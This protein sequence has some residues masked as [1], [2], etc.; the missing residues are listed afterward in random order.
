M[1]SE[2]QR[3]HQLSDAIDTGNDFYAL[4]L[5]RIDD[6]ELDDLMEKNLAERRD[7]LQR[8]RSLDG[9]YTGE[10]SLSTRLEVEQAQ[11]SV[12]LESNDR[13]VY[14]DHLEHLEERAELAFRDALAEAQTPEMIA[15]L[16][17]LAPRFEAVQARMRSGRQAA[18]RREAPKSL[19]TR[20]A[21]QR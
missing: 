9:A 2:M 6:P 1:N 20:I 10:D 12:V 7:I 18:S 4:A 19:A 17:E 11:M 15:L 13:Y 8:L 5:D 21:Q 14:M 16:R 3:I